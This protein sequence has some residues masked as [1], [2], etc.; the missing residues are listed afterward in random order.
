[1]SRAERLR[2]AQKE[3]A[4]ALRILLTEKNGKIVLWSALSRC[5]LFCSSYTTDVT[6]TAFREGRRSV[7][8]ELLA[9][10]QQ[11]DPS[12]FAMMML[13]NLETPHEPSRSDEPSGS[14]AG[15]Y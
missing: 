9:M 5:G 8:L 2:D 3:E 7:G 10:I 4:E 14:D 12:A 6:A 13:D 1:M 11:V 15:T